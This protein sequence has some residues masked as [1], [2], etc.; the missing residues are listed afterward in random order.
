MNQRTPTPVP[1]D[2]LTHHP[3]FTQLDDTLWRIRLASHA[4]RGVGNLLQPQRLVADELL[5]HVK[6]S[7]VAHVL[8]F[9]GEVLCAEVDTALGAHDMLEMLMLR[10]KI[11]FQPTEGV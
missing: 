11:T 6:R 3:Q 9:F 7:E 4:L 1:G 5:D 2:L 10:Q 8:E